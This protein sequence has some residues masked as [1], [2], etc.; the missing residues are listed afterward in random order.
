VL[1][2]QRGLFLPEGGISS[3]DKLAREQKAEEIF[4]ALL[5]RFEREGRNV[6]DKP[7]SPTYA[8]TS[9]SK[10]K[11]ANAFRRDDLAAA[12][13]RLFAASKIHVESS[14]DRRDRHRGSGPALESL[15]RPRRKTGRLR[16]CPLSGVKRTC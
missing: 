12:M 5:A 1:R 14:A 9:F 7:T 10:E 3:L 11:D 13:R 4:L 15:M 16:E 2:Y 6:S 8:P